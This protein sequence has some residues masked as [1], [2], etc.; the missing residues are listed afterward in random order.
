MNYASK[1]Y[2]KNIQGE[3]RSNQS[4]VLAVIKEELE[5][6]DDKEDC[7]FSSHLSMGQESSDPP[8]VSGLYSDEKSK[9]RFTIRISS[10]SNSD[11]CCPSSDQVVYKCSEKKYQEQNDVK[12]KYEVDEEIVEEHITLGLKNLNIRCDKSSRLRYSNPD[13]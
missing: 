7:D 8:K 2:L 4:S 12:A 6:F 11:I 3:S 13:Y 10:L 9:S 1:D 5:S